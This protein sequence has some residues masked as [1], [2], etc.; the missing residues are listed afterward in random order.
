MFGAFVLLFVLTALSAVAALSLALRAR[1]SS[2]AELVVTVTVLW[3]G[4][5]LLPI[6]GLGWAHRLDAT[7]L[8]LAS[9]VVSVTTLALSW[10]RGDRA[11]YGRDLVRGLRDLLRLPVEAIR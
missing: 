11:A 2:G 9:L 5:I 8:A 1:P 7:N 3:N 4:L 10:R 6:Y